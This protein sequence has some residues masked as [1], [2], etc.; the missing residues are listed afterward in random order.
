MLDD[1]T[2]RTSQAR[3]GRPPKPVDP[4]AS[5]AARLGAGIRTRRLDEGLTLAALGA[6]VGYS[7]QHVSECELGKAYVSSTFVARCD[8]ALAAAG[9]ITCLLPAVLDEQS[10]RR[11]ARSLARG[12]GTLDDVD[13]TTRRGLLEA[14]AASALTTAVPTAAHEVDPEL[15]ASRMRLLQLLDRHVGAFGPQ[16]ALRTVAFEQ[17]QIA[18]HREVARGALRIR[19][20]RVEAR[21]AHFAA[22]LSGDTLPGNRKARETAARRALDLANE[23]DYPEIAAYMLQRH[24]RWAI[25]DGDAPGAIAL[26]SRALSLRGTTPRMRALCALK[27]AQAHALAGDQHA[28]SAR[29]READALL[30]PPEDHVDELGDAVLHEVSA[31]YVAADAARCQL[32][33]E[34]TA[35]IAAFDDLLRAWPSDRVRDRGVQQARLA[36]ACAAAGEHDRAEAEGRKALAIARATKSATATREIKRLSATLR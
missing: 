14:G 34:P 15:P 21:W 7:P 10:A 24:G 22:W 20:Q 31:P 5:C 25:E 27:A 35:A 36:A 30:I 28:T 16:E 8:E 6:L 3:R 4:D 33:L 19:L 23:A 29:L 12:G 17:R 26:T 13:P 18:R 11:D 32:W 9:A 2:S 1:Q